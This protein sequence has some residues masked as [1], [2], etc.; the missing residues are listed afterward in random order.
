M[1]KKKD[2][3]IYFT[4]DELQ[5]LFSVLWSQLSDTTPDDYKQ[6]SKDMAL[7]MYEKVRAELKWRNT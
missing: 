5:G 2:N 1:A 6:V 3:G 4:D 7:S